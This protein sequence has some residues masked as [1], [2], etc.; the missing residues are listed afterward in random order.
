M[1]T[2]VLLVVIV[3]LV[4]S[5]A[6]YMTYRVYQ[7][8]QQPGR[9]QQSFNMLQNQME[10]LRRDTADALDK[11]TRSV[12]QQSTDITHQINQRLT[13]LDTSMR[14]ITGQVNTRLDS[15]VRVI[16]DVSATMGQLQKATQQVEEVGKDI[17]TLQNILRAPKLRG[18]VGEL[19]LGN[20]LDQ[21]VPGNFELQHRFASGETVDAIIKLSHKFV[22]VDAKFPL[23]NFQKLA[24]ATEEGERRALRKRFL[25]DV[26]KHVDTIS[27]K[28]IKPDEGTFDF[29]LMYIPAENVYYETVIRE[30]Q[31]EE[32]LSGYAVQRRVIPVSPN[33]LYA[34][35]QAIVYGLRGMQIEKQAQEILSHLGRLQQ[36]FG[37]FRED[38]DMMGAH[39]THT[40]NKYD[41]ASRR[42]C[43][44]EGKLAV[45]AQGLPE[46]AA[47][48][49]VLPG[50]ET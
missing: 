14:D 38:F 37:R 24:A 5:A 10:A 4:A 2:L 31:D 3:A 43:Q 46:P 34:Y 20:L 6:L 9:D 40:R 27:A 26:R 36:D 30:D 50:G 17:A 16:R 25:A 45:G 15:A 19:F 29:A 33:S 49:N 35:L 13:A 21:V 47:A 12:G 18:L 1:G 22:P 23:E 44:F 41:D 42:L 32:G 11:N 48:E 7:R 8:I 28:Y 39:L